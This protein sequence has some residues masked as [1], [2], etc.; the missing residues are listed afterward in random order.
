MKYLIWLVIVFAVIWWIRQQR[1]MPSDATSNKTS[2]E[3][4]HM[5]ESAHVMVPCV[6][7]GAHMP[8]AD[9]LQGQQGLYCSEAH[10]Q[11]HEG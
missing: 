4:S 8:H 2:K 5:D 9:A 3:P 11:R 10:R 6:H 1:Q 7:C